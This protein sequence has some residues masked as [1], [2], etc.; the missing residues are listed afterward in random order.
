MKKIRQ[1]LSARRD[2]KLREKLVE[3]TKGDYCNAIDCYEFIVNPVREARWLVARLETWHNKIPTLAAE[4]ME[5][6]N[7]RI[8]ENGGP[9]FS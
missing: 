1:W 3:V 5:L 4:V 6:V 7:K 8:K 9:D 2:R